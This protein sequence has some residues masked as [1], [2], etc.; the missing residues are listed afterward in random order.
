MVQPFQPSCLQGC[1]ANPSNFPCN[2]HVY[3]IHTAIAV[4]DSGD[5]CSYIMTSKFD[6]SSLQRAYPVSKIEQLSWKCSHT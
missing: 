3:Y 5:K 2:F 6:C 1:K 4:H